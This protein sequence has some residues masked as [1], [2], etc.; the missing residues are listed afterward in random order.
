VGICGRKV[1]RVGRKD[2]EA[3][4]PMRVGRLERVKPTLPWSKTLEVIRE[5]N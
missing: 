4:D 1:V 5:R 2:D 3:R